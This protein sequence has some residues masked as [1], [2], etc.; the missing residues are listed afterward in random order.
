MTTHVRTTALGVAAAR[1][2]TQTTTIRALAAA[3]APG[4]PGRIP[5]L[6]SGLEPSPDAATSGARFEADDASTS[7]ARTESVAAEVAATKAAATRAIDAWADEI[8]R[9]SHGAKTA[10][11][12]PSAEAEA[13]SAAREESGTGEESA[14]IKETAAIK[15]TVAIKESATIK[16]SAVD[17]SEVGDVHPGALPAG[18]DEDVPGPLTLAASAARIEAEARI[19]AAMIQ[20]RHDPEQAQSGLT[21]VQ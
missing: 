4:K 2:T 8:V 9:S 13:D 11:V 1:G 15:E 20:A 18:Q 14:T 6:V 10:K 5:P 17:D 7:G 3:A 16:E 12:E 19:R 21:P